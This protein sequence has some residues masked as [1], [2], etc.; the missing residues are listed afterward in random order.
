ME[1]RFESHENTYGLHIYRKL[2]KISK[3]KAD[4]DVKYLREEERTNCPLALTARKSL[5]AL[6]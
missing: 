5:M 3:R 4:S 6:G 2:E 1:I